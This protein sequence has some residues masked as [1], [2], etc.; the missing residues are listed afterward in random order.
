MMERALIEYVI[1]A[2]WQVPLL[3]G[4]AWLLLRMVRPAPLMQHRIWLA[5]LGLAVLL[6]LHGMS[7]TDVFAA[8]RTAMIEASH[9]EV[10]SPLALNELP[11]K[12]RQWFAF[13]ALFSARTGSL[14]LT[15]RTAH[16]LLR[17]YVATIA[18]GLFRVA[19][20]WRAARGLV[21]NSQETFLCHRDSTALKNLSD[22]LGIKAPQLRESREVSS[23]M[24]VGVAAPVLLLPEGFARHTEDEIQ[25]ALCHELAHIQRRDYLVNVACQLAAL[26]LAWHPVLD[27]VQQRIRMTREMVCDAMAAEEMKSHLGYAK[28]L[29][30]LAHSMLGGREIPA[31]AQFLGLFS[32]STLEERVMRLVDT[33][34]MSVRVKAARAASG[35]V[36]MIATGVIAMAFHVTPTMAQANAQPPATQN[37]PASA[38]TQPSVAVPESSTPDDAVK[39]DDRTR[40]TQKKHTDVR[41]HGGDAECAELSLAEQERI[42]RDVQQQVEDAQRKIAEGMAKLNSHEFEHRM[43]DFQRQMADVG[44]K[45]DSPELKQRIDNAQRQMAKDM[46]RLD[47]HVFRQR[48][49]DFQRQMT[50]VGP[51]LDS[52]E[53]KQRIDDAQ[54]QIAK[55]MA[56][57]DN[58]EFKHRM[59]DFQRQMTDVGPK[60]NG[61]EFK[62]RMD[63]LQRKLANVGPKV[64]SPEFKQRMDDLQRKLADVGPKLDSPEFKQR[65]DDFQRQM[66]EV[67][68]K[69]NSPEFKQRMDDLQKQMQ[70]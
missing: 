24:I 44:P 37:P 55:D 2:L 48:M 68:P 11:P 29:L 12:R 57:L 23:P 20:A 31:Q 59:D 38:S 46:A 1:N 15:P 27:W 69:L 32:N 13:P 54:R 5:V 26:P 45:L 19:R 49:D 41:H 35:A 66:T 63:D 10:L 58:H 51:K 16:W 14:R 70:K 67:G 65:M 40:V 4:G 33:T 6:P 64:D 17:L 25:A 18:I 42:D 34:T 30:A 56:R 7:R 43:D 52:P 62:Q 9:E 21:E 50:D 22:R 61:P 47:N 28:C 8:Q 53:F 60:L 39:Q 3:A 36:M